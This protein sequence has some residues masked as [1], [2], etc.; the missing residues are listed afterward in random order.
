MSIAM[1]AKKSPAL[2]RGFVGQECPTHMI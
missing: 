1:Q 2:R